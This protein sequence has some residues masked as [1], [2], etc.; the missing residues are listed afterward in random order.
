VSA[1]EEREMRKISGRYR[2]AIVALIAVLAALAIVGPAAADP[3]ESLFDALDV[4]A[5]WAGE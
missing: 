3:G 4:I 1:P 2:A 5:S